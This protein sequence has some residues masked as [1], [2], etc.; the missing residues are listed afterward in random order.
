MG[1]RGQ[2]FKKIR[3]FLYESLT[4]STGTFDDLHFPVE[5]VKFSYKNR[6]KEIIVK[7]LE[8]FSNFS[9]KFYIFFLYLP[10]YTGKFNGFYRER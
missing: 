5:T 9:G 10:I 2:D 7:S 1:Y 8:K 4:V 3:R 6:L